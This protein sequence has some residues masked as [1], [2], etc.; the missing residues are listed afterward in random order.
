MFFSSHEVFKRSSDFT[1]LI[2]SFATGTANAGALSSSTCS[3][4][5]KSLAEK[6]RSSVAESMG[7]EGRMPERDFGSGG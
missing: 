5:S 7:G 4:K 3:P 1:F 2:V 6:L